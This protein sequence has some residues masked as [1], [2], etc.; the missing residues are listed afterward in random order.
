GAT[1][2]ESVGT[3]SSDDIRQIPAASPEVAIQGRVSG[4]QVQ[5]ES[6]NPGAP[7][8]VR[9]RGV[10]T[11]GNTQPLFVVDGL[12]V[13]RADDPTSS[14]LRTIDPNDIESISVLKDASAS[15]VYGM[16]SANGVWL[17]MPCSGR[18]A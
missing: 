7:V 11:V 4:I 18:A 6:G 12:P 10:G 14:P 1:L 16:Q 2:T 5:Q 17:F 15:G 9:I 8:A 3:I 13:G